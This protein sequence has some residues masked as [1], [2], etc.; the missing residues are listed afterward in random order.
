MA[1]IVLV[2]CDGWGIREEKEGN[3]PLLART[4]VTDM[5]DSTYP[6]CILDASGKAV[7]LPDG[8]QGNS[9]VGHLTI[10]SG[11]TIYQALMR[12]NASIEDGSFFSNEALSSV[13]RKVKEKSSRLHIMGLVQDEGV[14]AHQEHLFAL[15]R[16]AK[17]HDVEVIVHAI[18]DGRD[19]PPKSAAGYV[20]QVADVMGSEGVGRF[21]VVV[22]RY[23]AMDRDKRWARTE[24]AYRALTKADGAHASDW[25]SAIDEAYTVGETDEFIKPRIIKDYDGMRE[26]DGLIFFNYR[27]DRAR[28]ITQALVEKDFS[29]F[30]T[31][32]PAI[33]MVAM[34][35]YY[36]GISCPVAFPP[37]HLTN[38][39][40]DVIADNGFR[41]LRISE[42]EKYAHVT[43]FF[44]G[45]VEEP[46]EREDRILIPSPKVA[47]YD[48]KPEMS[49]HEITDNLVEK[50][51]D[52]DLV[53]TNLVNGDMVGHTGD[54]DA[55]VSAVESVDTCLGRIH[56]EVKRLG[57]SLLVTADHGNCEEMVCDNETSHTTNPVRLVCMGPG[58]ERLNRDRGTLADIAPTILFLLGIKQPEEMDGRPLV[59]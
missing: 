41:Q 16:M 30:H 45:L 42:T 29:A 6:T 38:L 15:L 26:D 54:I 33:H 9:E 5:L 18:T 48:Q 40:G 56:D 24:L 50:M 4:P 39:L 51:G 32:H 53:I 17:E 22:G 47:T 28:Q 55:A 34:T 37:Q 23:Y 3:A 21:G 35:E 52:Y 19:T 10:G 31:D 2:I 49:V 36:D 27:Y 8:Y 43:F 7:G 57:G 20:Q 58:I 12:I 14:H 1:P 13:M 11:R 59:D 46:H 25:Q 44:N